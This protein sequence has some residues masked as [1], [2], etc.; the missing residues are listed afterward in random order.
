MAG[1][2]DQTSIQSAIQSVLSTPATP[3]PEGHTTALVSMIDGN[4]AS[5]AIAKKIG[6]HWQV[7]GTVSHPWTGPAIEGGFV[8]HASW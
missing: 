4:K 8:L 2:F 5:L 3:I 6:D 7:E 1:V